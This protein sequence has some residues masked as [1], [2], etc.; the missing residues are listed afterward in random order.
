MIPDVQEATGGE[1][2]QMGGLS[3]GGLREDDWTRGGVLWYQAAHQ[4]GEEW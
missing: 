1:A 4:S 2:V 3:E